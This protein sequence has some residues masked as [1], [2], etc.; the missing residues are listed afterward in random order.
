VKKIFLKIGVYGMKKFI[1]YLICFFI[2][3]TGCITIDAPSSAKIT[4]KNDSS[5][6]LRLSINFRDHTWTNAK[7]KE[8]NKEIYME[9]AESF[10][11]YMYSGLGAIPPNP[12][13]QITNII[14]IDE[15]TN[16]IIGEIEDNYLYLFIQNT[17]VRLYHNDYLF[18]ITDKLL[19]MDR[20]N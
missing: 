7:G 16:E 2:L 19:F 20:N 13:D 17:R 4:I 10:I 1:Y 6:N 8:I 9:K 12:Y 3:F 15:N 11:F 5:Y 14:F 18:L